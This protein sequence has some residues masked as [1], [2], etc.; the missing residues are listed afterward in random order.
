MHIF[1]VKNNSGWKQLSGHMERDH[2]YYKNNVDLSKSDQNIKIREYMT[3]AEL[4][5]H[6]RQSGVERKVRP[7]A[8][9]ALNVICT[10][11]KD[12]THA[13]S[14]M[15]AWGEAVVNATCHSLGLDPNH[16]AGAE[17]HMDETTPHIHFSVIPIVEDAAGKAKLS[18]KDVATREHLQHLHDDVQHD[19]R[20]AGYDGKYVSDDQE[21]RGLGKESLPELKR[22]QF[23]KEDFAEL[24]AEL[25]EKQIDLQNL[26]EQH[27]KLSK[28]NR[29]LAM[30]IDKKNIRL[31]RLE[32]GIQEFHSKVEQM[33]SKMVEGFKRGIDEH[34]PPVVEQAREQFTKDFTFA[35]LDA[36]FKNAHQ[37][38]IMSKADG[39]RDH[40][41][42]KIQDTGEREL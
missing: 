33:F 35:P 10:L 14:D 34:K 9:V 21:A 5:E 18:A 36:R 37:A 1:K 38:S 8:V 31:G 6:I 42:Q 17:I 4:Q 29:K 19:L 12:E 41:L 16:L 32:A 39:A 22:R 30:E 27:E 15:R 7:D 28:E 20:A 40:A 11:P 2:S 13:Q 23:I 25:Q 24:K 26:K 3:A